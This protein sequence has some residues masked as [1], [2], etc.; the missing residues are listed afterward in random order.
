MRLRHFGHLLN[1]SSQVLAAGLA[2]DNDWAHAPDSAADFVA[3]VCN[4][5][6]RT[7]RDPRLS[8]TPASRINERL[9]HGSPR[10]REVYQRM[11]K[12]QVNDRLEPSRPGRW[13]DDLVALDWVNRD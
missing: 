2:A 13:V 8:R 5:D 7:S 3:A 11:D 4:R 6:I 12:V 10:S 9:T 1:W